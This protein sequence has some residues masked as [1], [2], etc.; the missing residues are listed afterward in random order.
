MWEFLIKKFRFSLIL[1]L[2]ILAS[3]FLSLATLPIE[4]M[5]EVKIPYASVVTFYSGASPLDVE[6]LVTNPIEDGLDSLEDVKMISSSSVENMSMIFI[7]FEA[8]ADIAESVREAQD[9]VSAVESQL[10]DDAEDP[11]VSELNY[12]NTPILTLSL[13]ADLSHTELAEIAE[14]MQSEITGVGFV[15]DVELIGVR[16]ERV[17]VEL[18]AD[19]LTHYGVSIMEVYGVLV[20]AES[21]MPLGSVDASNKEYSLRFVS[22]LQP[23]EIENL[24]VRSMGESNIYL[25]DI[26][27]V[28]YGIEDV[29]QHARISIEG[30][31]PE[32]AISM[33]I[34]KKTGGDIIRM[35]DE[36]YEITGEFEAETGVSVLATVDYAEDIQDQLGSLVKSGMQTMILVAFILFLSLG[37][38]EALVAGLSIPLTFLISFTGISIYGGT[39]NFLSLFSLILALGILVD[40]G[41]VITEGMHT[42]LVAGKCP[43]VVALETVREYQLPLISGTM[44]TVAAFVPM[45]MMT[46]IMGEFIKHIPKTVILTLLASLFVGLGILPVLG[47]RI[48]KAGANGG[49]NGGANVRKK[50]FMERFINR[51]KDDYRAA[52]DWFCSKK[53]RQNRLLGFMIFLFFLSSALPIT[54]LLEATMFPDTDYRYYYISVELPNGSSLEDTNLVA[55]QVEAILLA[56]PEVESFVTTVGS[57]SS[58]SGDGLTGG[59]GADNLANFTVNLREDRDLTSIEITAAQRPLVAEIANAD[60]SVVEMS[61]GPPSAMPID[62]R[63]IG[64][65]LD[66][67]QDYSDQAIALLE[68]IPGS[69][70]L[71]SSLEETVNEFVLSVDRQKAAAAGLDPA[72]ISQVARLSVAG[73]SVMTLKD[74]GEEVEVYLQVENEMGIDEV[75]AL[76]IVSAYGTYSLEN[77]VDVSFEP[78]PTVVVHVDGDRVASITGDIK[79]GYMVADILAEFQDEFELDDAN[80][81]A[82]YGGDLEEIA[83]SFTSLGYAML[84][85]VLL[86]IVILILQFNSFRQ[87]GMIVFTIPL[88]LIGVFTGLTIA[89]YPFSFPA[90]VGIVALAGIVVNNAIILIDKI[91]K[92]IAAGMSKKEAILDAGVARFQPILLTTITTVVGIAPL[93]LS[94]PTWGPLGFTIISG[95][96]FSTV[97]TLFVVPSLYMRFNK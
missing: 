81:R 77:F 79:D 43:K 6:E 56:T 66:K 71:G 37:F 85:G 86:I 51:K 11:M 26:A 61:D 73:I 5:P 94:D 12:S 32:N 10:P 14:N 58:L 57:S 20:A 38:R 42:R 91:N 22:E 2:A 1:V 4:A 15:S 24:I 23:E 36:I 28:T 52:L 7:E 25:R 78:T 70:N 27:E 62:F 84:V 69:L 3:G 40:T 44:T 95:L 63:I 46:G 30:S 93:A 60:V 82:E 35:V 8:S 41:I 75:L 80:Y 45:L 18:E 34:Y 64:P 68:E 67:L 88:A 21:S 83:E 53:K 17:L 74:A 49:E 65:D 19:N 96:I 33:N 47:S 29:S 48:L 97:L 50:S 89:G 31:E 90:F 76:P 54:G 39:F 16:E 13:S 55:E 92:N 59:T 9:A 72:T 87:A